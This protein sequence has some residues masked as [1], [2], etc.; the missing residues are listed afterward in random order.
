MREVTKQRLLKTCRVFAT[1][2][3]L[4][5][6]AGFF[7]VLEAGQESTRKAERSNKETPTGTWRGESKCVVRPSACHDEDSLY[8][9]AAVSGSQNR[10]T[11]AASKVVSGR[12]VNMG[13]SDCLYSPE[14][15]TLNC[16][17][18][19]GSAVRLRLDGDSLDGDMT[20]S[21]GTLWRKI[22]LSKVWLR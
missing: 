2:F 17:L 7:T 1:V 13:R 12:E 19:N 9:V 20:L 5:P 3:A 15:R 11:I 21:D 22:A 14:N 4:F 10:F 6:T 8:R 16:A 18:P